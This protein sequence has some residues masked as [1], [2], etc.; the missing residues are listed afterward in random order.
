MLQVNKQNYKI[1]AKLDEMICMSILRNDPDEV[2][3]ILKL[4]CLMYDIDNLA[5]MKTFFNKEQAS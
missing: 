2:L 3:N 5:L 1:Q 4:E